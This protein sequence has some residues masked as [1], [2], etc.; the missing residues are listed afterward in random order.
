MTWCLAEPTFRV[1]L[2]APF[3]AQPVASGMV[4]N[5]ASVRSGF[6]S[7][8]N[9]LGTAMTNNTPPGP[10]CPALPKAQTHHQILLAPHQ[11]GDTPPNICPLID[12]GPRSIGTGSISGPGIE[13]V[14]LG[15]P[16]FKRRRSAV[17]MTPSEHRLV[18]KKR[19]LSGPDQVLTRPDLFEYFTL[20]S[21]D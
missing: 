13:R 14:D 11:S 5:T 15:R 6:L 2:G 3:S 10:Y 8:L 7:E 20:L 19:V 18:M 16:E 21:V 1:R 9:R 4:R 17:D 12:A